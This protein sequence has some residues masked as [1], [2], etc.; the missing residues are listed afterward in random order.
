MNVIY[1]GFDLAAIRYEEVKT[2][3]AARNT[4]HFMDWRKG[5]F[6]EVSILE[7]WVAFGLSPSNSRCV[8]KDVLV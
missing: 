6:A 5:N 4:P 7:H 1:P 8:F 2:E 3:R